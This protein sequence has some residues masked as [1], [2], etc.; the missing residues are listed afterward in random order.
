M[1]KRLPA[2]GAVLAL[3]TVRTFAKGHPWFADLIHLRYIFWRFFK[4][5][6]ILFLGGKGEKFYL[7]STTRLS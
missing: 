6:F 3:L 4:F 7:E 5:Y 2:S 1:G